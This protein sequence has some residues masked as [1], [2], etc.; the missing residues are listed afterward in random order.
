MRNKKTYWSFIIG[1][2]MSAWIA[3]G[4]LLWVFY[5]ADENLS[6]YMSWVLPV[7]MFF[8]M[9]FFWSLFLIAESKKSRIFYLVAVSL[10][11]AAVVAQGYWYLMGVILLAA[12]LI[13]L[14]GVDWI[15][16][17]QENRIVIQPGR[18]LRFGI[19]MITTGL[20]LLVAFEYYFAIKDQINQNQAP[21]IEIEVP[22][23]VV[24]AA[25]NL[26]GNFFPGETMQYIANGITVDEY[27]QLAINNSSRGS[28][29]EELRSSAEKQQG[30][31][32]TDEEIS[33]LN[34]QLDLLKTEQITKDE[35]RR[36]LEKQLGMT[37]RGDD[38]MRDVLVRMVN[39]KL[40]KYF[41]YSDDSADVVPLWSAVVLFL[42]IKT[43]AW[44]LSFILIFAVRL[45]YRI[46]VELGAIEVECIKKDVEVIV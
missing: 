8:L 19:A 9:M 34:E 40:Y 31:K 3:W 17:E 12:L 43:L 15:K 36:E 35:Y 6:G 20:C 21:K 32:L 23:N 5:I 37:L 39:E 45:G 1:A 22:A 25:L 7:S 44:L 13:I 18:L 42:T 38:I 28:V 30:R 29:M 41:N 4:S 24:Y 2:I 10:F 33:N 46:M 27:I 26:S 14:L 11:P 16:K